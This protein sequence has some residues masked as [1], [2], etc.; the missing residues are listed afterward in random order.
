MLI[1][2]ALNPTAPGSKVTWKVVV[3]SPRHPLDSL[4]I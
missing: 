4:S 1:V 2:A 3:P